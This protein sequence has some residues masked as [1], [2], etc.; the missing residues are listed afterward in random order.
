VFAEDTIFSNIYVPTIQTTRME[1]LLNQHIECKKPI[2][3]A[4]SAG[5]GKTAIMNNYLKKLNPERHRKATINF[6]NFTD[7]MLVQKSIESLLEKKSGKRY[8]LSANRELIYFIDD[9]NMPFVDKYGTQTPIALL[10]QL[11]DYSM[12]YDRDQVD[13]RKMIEDILFTS[14]VNPKSGSF[15]IDLRLQRH[16]SVFSIRMSNSDL[17]RHIY[18][19]I[20]QSHLAQFDNSFNGLSEKLIEATLYV[21]NK[22]LKDT[23]F[24]PSAR[25]FHY[26]FNLRDL[27]KIVEGL[28]M[29]SAQF[30]KN[31]PVKMIKLWVH[32]C[33]RVFEDRLINSDDVKR[34]K[35]YLQEGFKILAE[36]EHGEVLK[37]LNIFT[38]FVAQHVL[39][40]K[41]YL[42]VQS[43]DELKH[44]LEEKLKEYNETKPVM[45]LVLFDQAIE[46]IARICRILDQSGGH[47]L[48]VGVGGSGKRSLAKL[49]T[50]IMGMDMEQIV[51]SQ[52]FTLNDLKSFL[53]ELVKKAVK[54]PGT[55]RVFLLNDTQ[56]QDEFYLVFINDLLCLGFI[57]DLF[58]KEE[59]EGLILSLRNE[60][61]YNGYEDNI[62]G[63][64]AYFM[65]KL[66][67]NLHLI[68][69]FSPVGEQFRQRARKFPGLINSTMIDWYH[70]WANSALIDVAIR[71]LGELDLPSAE[72]KEAIALNMT[73]VHTSINV[74]NKEFLQYERRYNYTTPKSFLELIDFYK[75]LYT[76]KSSFIANQITRLENGLETLSKTEAQVL[77]LQEELK[78]KM[79][80]VEEESRITEELINQVTRESE[81][82][83]N[84]QEIANK[85]KEEVNILA[86]EA[87]KKAQRAT[88]ALEEALPALEAAKEAVK[89]IEKQS[90][91]EMKSLPKPPP[92]VQVVAKAVLILISNTK[93]PPNE[94]LT[95]TWQRA[96][97]VM[98]EPSKFLTN[99]LNYNG[100]TIEENKLQEV[101]QILADPENKGFEFIEL[102][103]KNTAAAYLGKWLTSMMK[104]NQV[105]KMVKPLDEEKKVAEQE[106]ALKRKELVLV[107]DKVDK[108]NKQVDE[109]KLKLE[110]AIRKKQ[111]V[112]RDAAEMKEKLE[113]AEKLVSDL[114]NENERW[115]ENVKNLKLNTKTI[116]GDALLS[117]EFVSYIGAF[118]VRLRKNLWQKTWIPNIEKFNIPISKGIN[119]LHI[120]T[121]DS[122]VAQWKNEGLPADQM[123]IENATIINSCT[124]W[125]LIID[126][127]LQGSSWI[128]GAYASDLVILSMSQDRW[129]NKLMNAIQMGKPVL[130]ENLS[131]E[132]DATLDPILNRAIIQKDKELRIDFGEGSI[133]YDPK[134]KLILQTKMSNPH[135]RPEIAAQC[136]IINFIVTE[137]GL[138][139]QLLAMVVNVEKP[140]LE[141]QKSDLVRK[142]NEFQVQLA[143]LEEK[144][145]NALSEADPE[146]ILDN[147]QLLESLD[148]TKKKSNEIGIQKEKA[149]QTELQINLQRELYRSVAT[150]GSTLYFLL[151]SLNFVE[152]MYQYSLEAFTTFFLKAIEKVTTQEEK[153]IE[154]LRKSIRFTIYQWVSR[155]LFEKQKWIFLS[156][157]MFRLMQKK[158]VE[159]QYDPAE[160]E[161]LF[162]AVPK[163]TNENPLD[164]LPNEAWGRIN[165]L[166]DLKE[167]RNL[168]QNI[169]KDAPS[170]FKDWYNELAP[171]DVKLPLDWKRLDHQPFRKLLV[172]RCL[173]PDRFTIALTNLIRNSLPDG[174][175]F[176]EMDQKNSFYDILS[177]S[178]QDAS[179]HTPIFFILSPGADP[180]KG[181][182]VL[183]KKN[184]FVKGQDFWDVALGQ[185]QESF[186]MEKLERAYKEGHWIILQ[187][188][189]LMPKWLLE[190]EKKLDQF[191]QNAGG[192][193]LNFRL[194][195]SAEPSPDIPIGILE[196][197]IKLTNEPPAGLKANLKR[198]WTSLRREDVEDK[199]PRMKTIL[200]SLCYF[201][202]T[203]IERRKF[204]A[205]GWNMFYP[206]NAGDL[207]D[208]SN[209]LYKYFEG[210]IG[211]IPWAD[212]TYIFGD[213][214][215]GG[216]IVDD[217][218]RKLCRNYLEQFM[219]EKLFDELEFF[220]FLENK[221]LSFKCPTP[222]PYDKY[223]EYIENNL[224]AETPLA[225]GLHYNAEIGF[226]TNNCETL[227]SALMELQPRD[228]SIENSNEE[229][230]SQ[231]KVKNEV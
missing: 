134:F 143:V 135:F 71:F 20:L 82:A 164:W 102:K 92:L 136:T 115:T 3:F 12:I 85:Q 88:I 188:V 199:D 175:S 178:I 112:E 125:P 55:P 48:L 58:P 1:Y 24:A 171:E 37:E 28:T 200:F 184:G 8:G 101:K 140:E 70:E 10:R 95:R 30:Y 16:F 65:D 114:S 17:L 151:S 25:K 99:L 214:M 163:Q 54:T 42:P 50:F 219:N 98:N 129:M 13:E 21:F 221:G 173:R 144:L 224:G 73:E 61:K 22:I 132:I 193:N 137:G 52:S 131:Q 209:V 128:R 170:R 107:L 11:V 105:F 152:H 186:A 227:L 47:A 6:N 83:S 165:R 231:V 89:C 212:L 113:T 181:V 126:P 150:E 139:D 180:V 206:F 160:L 154:D 195:L 75:Q 222:G 190:L 39:N 141:A 174:N 103:K 9:I 77:N 223:L 217:W 67:R 19:Q 91:T 196:R 34:F 185:G 84:E 40:E 4:G 56:I 167:F 145:L 215:Y 110:E 69:T 225:Y 64:R 207:R 94:P 18:S 57:P 106:V 41:A 53:Q 43:F 118:S 100:E 158:I 146:T 59:I 211:R 198:A 191:A 213:I 74:A 205:K 79:K 35:Q 78:I 153:R 179:S 96:V 26:Q 87:D 228:S 204:G 177:S 176:I 166:S 156:L 202:S 123:S 86:E 60:A 93:M 133:V 226:R 138:E 149:S 216:H 97:Q 38:S 230:Q 2:L 49:A 142:Q 162:N 127:Q 45:N 81:I 31:S 147:K 63:Y 51:V 155:G 119:P 208:S 124:R 148:S 159:I 210:S 15:T 36:E 7:S 116:I 80:E 104:Y 172:L 130:F 168:A 201:H 121:N 182:E 203:V 29:S 62:D 122:A 169:E 187:N 46:H 109:L 14:C 161:F 111:G 192:T 66:K 220:P 183:A 117:A 44:V 76:K 5:T 33:Q 72:I 120:L 157:M 197:C 189:H 108:I 23:A 68:L 194:F 32:E 229:G 218:D 27:S 90:I